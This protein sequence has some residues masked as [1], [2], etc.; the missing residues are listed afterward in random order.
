MNKPLA[1]VIPLG[2]AATNKDKAPASE[3]AADLF[4]GL[5]AKMPPVPGSISEE[6][7][8]H[9]Y[10]IGERLVGLNLLAEVDLGQFRIMCE[11]WALYVEAQRK[12]EEEGEYQP[13]PN[14]YMQLSPW[15]VARE[16]HANRYQKIADKFFLSP[17]ARKAIT[18]ENPNQGGLDLD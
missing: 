3:T 2:L 9:W 10:Y 14:N 7:R 18:I 17:R 6:A 8:K 5:K 11:T 15:A 1:A 16:R 12:V 13:T 4:Q